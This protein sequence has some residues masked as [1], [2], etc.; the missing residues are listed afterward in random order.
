MLLLLLLLLLVW[1]LQPQ[2]LRRDRHVRML[3]YWVHVVRHRRRR[4]RR[5]LL[6]LLL[7]LWRRKMPGEH[8]WPM[9]GEI[10]LDARVL[11][12]HL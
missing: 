6:L 4:Q 10:A 7:L 1:V 8:I 11:V 12:E 2:V 5:L 9:R 3:L